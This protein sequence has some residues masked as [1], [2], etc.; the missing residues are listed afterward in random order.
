[1]VELIAHE[2]SLT[3][4]EIEDGAEPE[5]GV[6]YIT[7]PNADLVYR[8]GALR[9]QEP[10]PKIGPKPSVD[11]FLTSLAETVG[12]QAIGVILSGT[13][14][15]GSHGVRAIRAAGGLT[16]C[17][18]ADSAKYDGMP[19]AAMQTGAVDLCLAVEDI[20]DELARVDAESESCSV[21]KPVPASPVV[22][23]GDP[24][25]QI[26]ATLEERTG[27]EL[28]DYKQSTIRRRIER[29][30]IATEPRP[31]ASR[32][33]TRSLPRSRPIRC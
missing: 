2:T 33:C 14:S 10:A 3:V 11:L 23:D 17:Q 22:H 26:L 16:I 27:S 7:P 32:R 29:R 6:I 8:D 21:R 9:L 25:Q 4:K 5:P 31:A 15:D 28:T 13:G 19:R 20:A 24:F 18:W 12:D 1:M 30:M